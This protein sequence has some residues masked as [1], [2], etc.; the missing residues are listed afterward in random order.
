M[1]TD[2]RVLLRGFVRSPGFT[3]LAVVSLALGIGLN[4][5]VF[6]LVNAL[7]WQSIRGVPHPQ[8]VIFGSRV[9]GVELE[10]LRAGVTT[11]DGLSG[12]VRVPV[13]IAFGDLQVS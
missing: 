5:A 10:Q 8:R 11:L 4:T 9:S 6:S 12:V 3:A 7:F 2:L 1:A 13:Q